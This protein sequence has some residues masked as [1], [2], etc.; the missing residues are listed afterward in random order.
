MRAAAISGYGQHRD[1]GADA[2]RPASAR[3]RSASPAPEPVTAQ[4]STSVFAAARTRAGKSSGV[5]APEA[6]RSVIRAPGP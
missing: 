5:Y 2:E 4:A 3:Q 6:A 1:G